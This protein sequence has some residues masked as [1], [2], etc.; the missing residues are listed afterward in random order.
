MM[1][2]TKNSD[3]PPTINARR[4]ISHP[5]AQSSPLTGGI[6]GLQ[7]LAAII[8]IANEEA[9]LPETDVLIA[10]TEGGAKP[11]Q[12]RLIKTMNQR[13]CLLDGCDDWEY[14]ADPPEWDNPLQLN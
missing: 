2:L 11:S 14:S 4:T 9:T 5:Q 6:R 10:T 8:N 12:S 7:K 13:K 1:N 3:S